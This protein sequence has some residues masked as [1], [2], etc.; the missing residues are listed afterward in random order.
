MSPEFGTSGLLL[1]S[2]EGETNMNLKRDTSSGA[3][4][5]TDASAYELARKRKEARKR[6]QKERQTQEMLLNS[7]LLRLDALEKAIQEIQENK[8][9]K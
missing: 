5:N 1:R 9:K 2:R 6:Q 8:K 3:L 4:I 7:I